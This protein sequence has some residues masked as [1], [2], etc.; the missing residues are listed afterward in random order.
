V[1]HIQ[2]PSLLKVI[3][4]NQFAALS[5]VLVIAA[6]LLKIARVAASNLKINKQM[7]T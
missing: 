6:G 7:L 1:W 4:A 3:S 2:E 5:P